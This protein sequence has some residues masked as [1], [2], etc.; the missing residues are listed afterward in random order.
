L[1]AK[2]RT[3]PYVGGSEHES[4]W[5]SEYG[6]LDKTPAYVCRKTGKV[7][8]GR[9]PARKVNAVAPT[10]IFDAMP[11]Q[12]HEAA[13]RVID[14]RSE[15]KFTDK[16]HGTI[17]MSPT[18]NATPPDYTDHEKKSRREDIKVARQRAVADV[19]ANR[20]PLTDDQKTL[21][22]KSD[23]RIS[24]QLGYDVSKIWKKKKRK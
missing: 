2:I 9:P 11:P 13:K 5:P 23:E 10:I 17:T 16:L 14:T 6:T 21:C 22:R 8:K 7:K 3:K 19:L 15:W 24:Q 20:A 12:Y 1:S 18:E 4:E